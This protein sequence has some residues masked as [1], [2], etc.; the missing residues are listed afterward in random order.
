MNGD[1]IKKLTGIEFDNDDVYLNLIATSA[2]YL[3]MSIE[4]RDEEAGG[5]IIAEERIRGPP[6]GIGEG[7]YWDGLL[8]CF[9]KMGMKGVEVKVKRI[10]GA[11]C[12]DVYFSGR[13]TLGYIAEVFT[14]MDM[15][16]LKR[17]ILNPQ[18]YEGFHIGAREVKG[19][20]GKTYKVL[21]IMAGTNSREF[22]P[23]MVVY[24][25]PEGG[26][27]W[28]LNKFT[29]G[30][31][32]EKGERVV[33]YGIL[34]IGTVKWNEKEKFTAIGVITEKEGEYYI[35]AYYVYNSNEVRVSTFKLE[36]YKPP[37]VSEEES[38]G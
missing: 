15:A 27:G 3:I 30:L 33:D 7:G 19:D 21:A 24:T 38:E 8:D 22:P 29:I 35:K 9:K 20:D 5:K 32:L 18:V 10:P 23:E 28:W 1:D 37:A 16:T 31:D 6:A 4:V 36:G 14:R 25:E 12:I 2:D 11:Y 13:F 34:G 26:K 17:Y